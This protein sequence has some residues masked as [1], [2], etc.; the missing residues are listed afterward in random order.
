MA[1]KFVVYI[2]YGV[3]VDQPDSFDVERDEEFDQL[4]RDAVSKMFSHGVLEVGTNSEIEYEDVTK[5]FEESN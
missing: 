5:E 1:K 2:T 4:K 3:Y